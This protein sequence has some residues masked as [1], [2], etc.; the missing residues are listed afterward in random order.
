M[1][2]FSFIIGCLIILGVSVSNAIAITPQQHLESV[3]YTNVQTNEVRGS[4]ALVIVNFINVVFGLLGVVILVYFLY[5]GFKWM[6]AQD[7]QGEVKKAKDIMKNVAIGAF[8]ILISY[9]LATF[10]TNALLNLNK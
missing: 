10:V 3:D 1:K 7:N 5:A 6:M 9:S 4:A 2:Y 8:V